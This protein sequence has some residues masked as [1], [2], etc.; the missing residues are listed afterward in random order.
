MDKE[1]GSPSTICWQQKGKA[2]VVQSAGLT[3]K[4]TAWGTM[5]INVEVLKSAERTDAAHIC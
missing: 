2:G 1:T 5:G 3:L 4:V